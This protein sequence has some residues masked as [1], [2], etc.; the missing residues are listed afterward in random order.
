MPDDAL[1]AVADAGT[2]TR[3]EVLRAQVE[4]MLDDPKAARFARGFLDQ[5]L[6]LGTLLDMKPDEISVEYDDLLAWSM[7]QETRRFFDEVLA[8]DLPT[9][10]FFH[11]EWTFLNA[12]L[13]RH[14]GVSGI[15]GLELRKVALE[16]EQRRGGVITHA[17]VL[18]LTTNASYTS[19]IKR[20]AWILER[21]LGTPPPPPP[22]D[23]E[24]VEPDIRGA[25]T[26]REQLAKHKNVAVCASCHVRIDPP[27]FAL[28]SYDVVGG[29][30]DRYRVKKGGPGTSYE[31]LPRYPG[32]KV[33][34]AKPVETHGETADGR[35][36][37][38]LAGYKR[39]VLES[40]EG[41]TRNLAE[42]LVVYATGAEVDF[43]D[44]AE[45][46]RIVVASGGRFRS[47]VQA[48]VQS[49]L[50]LGK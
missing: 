34:F 22:P 20:G 48:V 16:P 43:A 12:R 1:R 38:D 11:S 44:R 35:A 17:S 6:D 2:L 42:K 36:F 50:F 15:D 39:L 21:L 23:V 5:W 26:I 24:A 9:A 32:R 41:L 31:E 14:Y 46:E 19:P 49:P 25:T 8:R 7:E 3:P 18:K 37:A 45:I 27:G 29:L 30:R 4:R 47:L 28:E 13:A 10:S 33:Y 40:P